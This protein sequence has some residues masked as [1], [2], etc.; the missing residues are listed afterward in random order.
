MFVIIRK[1]AALI[2]MYNSLPEDYSEMKLIRNFVKTL[3]SEDYIH[4]VSAIYKNANDMSFIDM[5]DNKILFVTHELS[6]TGAPKVALETLKAIRSIYGVNPLVVSM[7]NGEMKQDYIKEGFEVHFINEL[8]TKKK[9]FQDFCNKFKL[10]FVSSTAIDF[11]YCVK[12][13]KTPVIWYS[14]EIFKKKEDIKIISKFIK[15]FSII[16]CGSPLTQKCIN[17]IDGKLNTK[18]L[19]YGLKEENYPVIQ[20]DADKFIFIYPATITERKNQKILVEAVQL[21]PK[22]IKDKITVYIIGSPLNETDEYYTQILKMAE[23]MNEI[24]IIPNI[25]LKELLEYYAKADCLICPSTQD[26][27]PVIV[28]YAFMFKKL[29]LISNKIGQALLT[30]NNENAVLFNPEDKTQLKNC[31][32]DIVNNKEKYSVVAQNGRKIYDDYF[33]IEMFNQE[34]KNSLDGYLL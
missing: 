9:I 30:K 27:M 15:D 33:S 19:M 26:P 21:L 6:R 14:H 11:M 23:G 2:N 5:A 22:E 18:L 29:A 31:I 17:D 28:T 20:K 4:M 16:L 3:A 1:I 12:D 13:L 10:I 25:P 8:P 32:I 24:K 7:K 34:L